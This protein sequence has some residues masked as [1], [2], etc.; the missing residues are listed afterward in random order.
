ML[1]STLICVSLL[2]CSAIF[3][4]GTSPQ[5]VTH[6][7]LQAVHSDGTSSFDDSGPL[8]VSVEGILLNSPEEYLTPDPNSTEQPWFMGGQWQIYVQGEG[9]D[10][11]GTACWMGQ[12]YGNGP[13]DENYKNQQWLDELARLNR[14]PQTGHIFRPGD[15]VRVTGTYLFY[16]G[17]LNINENHEISEAFD[18]TVEL[19]EPAAGLPQPE[20]IQLSDVKN[21]DNTD[22]FDETRNT[23]GEYY[24]SRLVKLEDVEITNPENWAPGA[25]LTASNGNGLT[26]PVKLGLGKGF[27]NYSCPEGQIDIVGVFDQEAPGY[28]PDSTKGYRLVVLDHHGSSE[29]L[30]SLDTNRGNKPADINGDFI[31]DIEDF[32]ELSL[33]WLETASGL[34]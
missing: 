21:P 22:L 12:N 23:G 14:D 3:A 33:H 25:E 27:E 10:H 16:A 8:T 34:Y 31:V 5:L 7:Q 6:E 29:V 1:K 24:Q 32:A 9:S 19:L 28:P 26:L 11:A 15:R 20:E 13:G 18:F 2:T 17:K 30:G 4:A